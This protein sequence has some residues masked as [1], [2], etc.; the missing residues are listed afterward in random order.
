MEDSRSWSK[1][2]I[3]FPKYARFAVFI[4]FVFFIFHSIQKISDFFNINSKA[5]YT[6]ISYGFRF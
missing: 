5:S 6:H 2:N 3:N 1:T 4:I